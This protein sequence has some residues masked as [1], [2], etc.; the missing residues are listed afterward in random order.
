[1]K[2]VLTL[3]LLSLFALS[4]SACQKGLAYG[5][6]NAVIVAAPQ[7]WWPQLEDSVF[8]VL[9]PDV[10]TLRDERMFRLRYEDPTRPDWG[11][12]R[13]FKEEVV[14][15][16]RDDPWIAEVLQELDDT[17]TVEVPGIVET[18]NVWAQN[19]MVTAILVDPSGDVNEQVLSLVDEVHDALEARFRQGARMRMFVSGVD[20]VMADSVMRIA[21]FGMLLPEVYRF[22]S[23]DSLYVFRNDN[24]DPSELIRQF[25]VTWKTPMPEEA[26][27]VDSLL[28]WKEALSEQYYSYPQVVEREELRTRNLQ[29]GEMEITE[30]RGAWANPPESWPAAGPFILWGVTCPSQDRYYLIDAWLYAPGKDKWEYILQLETILE[31]FRCGPPGT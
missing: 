12:K 17:V 27:P 25:G 29:M 26:L 16:S 1:M 20:S 4:N 22:G 24:P 3:T 15:G 5:D 30:V 31:S 10:F 14:I 9:S 7:D 11:L 19:Q 8:A 18:R 21:H 23:E 6:P 2:K 13:M 28:D